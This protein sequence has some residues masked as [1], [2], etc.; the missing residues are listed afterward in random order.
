[1]KEYMK[2]IILFVILILCSY[3]ISFWNSYEGVKLSEKKEIYISIIE[4]KV[5][6]RIEVFSNLDLLLLQEKLNLKLEKYELFTQFENEK[7][8]N[9]VAL[10]YAV[11]DVVE[12]KINPHKRIAEKLKMFQYIPTTDNQVDNKKITFNHISW[13]EILSLDELVYSDFEK[14]NAKISWNIEWNASEVQVTFSNNDSNF[15]TDVFVLQRFKAWDKMFEYHVNAK[16]EVLDYGLNRYEFKITH[17]WGV[18]VSEL[19]VNVL[20]DEGIS[21]DTVKKDKEFIIKMKAELKNNL[22]YIREWTYGYKW[23]YWLEFTTLDKADIRWLSCN[24]D[25]WASTLNLFIRN[26][27]GENN[28]W[29]FWN[30]C[31]RNNNGAQMSFF[32]L[33]QNEG[34]YSYEKRYIDLESGI[35]WSYVLEKWKWGKNQTMEDLLYYNTQL[36]K[37][38]EDYKSIKILDSFFEIFF[39]LSVKK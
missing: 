26:D 4:K 27:L 10:L 3:N 29:F 5:L 16:F 38:N 8:F 13:E 33:T 11:H 31:R 35:Y 28:W 9:K 20:E 34:V 6:S 36:K 39:E 17:D 21:E 32:L 12:S 22:V 2:K 25:K 37:E 30:T 14:G 15:E 23:I 1:M 24:L 18:S 19:L 7:E